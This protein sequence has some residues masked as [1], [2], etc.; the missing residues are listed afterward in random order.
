MLSPSGGKGSRSPNGAV[1]SL[2]L[3]PPAPKCNDAA[4]AVVFVVHVAVVAVLAFWKGLPALRAQLDK[5]KS[6]NEPPQDFSMALTLVGIL[7]ATGVALSL[8]WMQ[9]L[10]AYASSMIRIALWLNVAMVLVFAISTFAV[11]PIAGLVFL[12]LVAINVWYIYAVQNRIG[13]ASANLKAACAA[14]KD[15]SA[16]FV[17][18]LLLVVQQTLWLALWGLSAMGVHQLFVEADPSCDQEMQGAFGPGRG[19]NNG[20]LCGGPGAGVT[21][22]FL[23]IS[24]YWGQ[25]VLQNILTCTTAGVVATWWYQPNAQK[26][27]VGALYRSV[28]TSFGSICFGSLIVAVLQALRTMANMAKQRAREEESTAL[29]CF[30]CMAE[31]ILSCLANI[32]E[33]INQWAY[34]YVGIYGYPFR[35]SGKAV[36]D[37]FN[38]RG[39]TAV[40]N[41]DL[42][43]S[44]LTF[45]ALGVGVVTCCI[46]LLMAKF[47][48]AAWFAGLGSQAGVYGVMATIGFMSGM[49]MAMIL[50]QVVI[51]A[52]HT[53]FVCFAEV[54]FAIVR[55][56]P[57]AFNR[58][59]P[60]EYD[61]LVAGWR[62][63]HGDA[64][65]AAYG[66]AV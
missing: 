43:S 40:I 28:T 24:V 3:E 44:A 4:F 42:T 41:D 16:V 38:N 66:S 50:A 1:H 26:A 63:F 61:D 56:D 20:G 6:E 19:R 31:C 48:P 47:A 49:S 14:V 59:H 27:T 35:T 57:I 11:N 60:K 9:F 55:P 36:M 18:A 23:L 15:H 12:F 33:Y 2:R 54:C 52:L 34:V 25:Q 65:V 10:M 29:A 58:N 45:G 64:L 30:A 21:L 39:W 62:Q 8:A 17:V 32:M 22:F 51:A 7:T 46:G 53:I 13:F 37:L 5:H